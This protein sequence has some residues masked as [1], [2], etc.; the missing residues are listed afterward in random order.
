MNVRGLGRAVAVALALMLTPIA[1]MAQGFAG[2][3]GNADGFAHPSPNHVLTFP[4]D[5]AAHPGFR[6]EWWYVTANLTGQDGQQYGVQWT[7]FRTALRPDDTG[8][9]G[10][11]SPQVWLGHAGLSTPDAHFSAQRLARGG[12]GL[13]G[14]RTVPFGAWVDEWH[15]SAPESGPGGIAALLLSAGGEDFSFELD[16]SA[17]GP[18]VAHGQN[19]YS[20]KSASGQASTYYSQPFY[21]A[22]GTLVF[23]AQ[24]VQVS[25]QAW[26]DREWS[27]QPLADDQDGWDW[28]S[29]HLDGGQKLMGFRLR[30]KDGGHF[31]SGTWISA[32][33]RATALG[34]DELSLNPL[35]PAAKTD[36][37]APVEWRLVVP[38]HGV[39]V[40]VSAMNPN[41]WMDVT[42]PYWEGPVHV[43]GSHTGR[44]FL[45]MTGYR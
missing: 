16:L 20:V 1:A 38:A 36:H 11:S 41:S 26:L 31:H 5:H 40:T 12:L 25:G 19:G 6:I 42:P 45:E 15:I 32:D 23:G 4:A 24:R 8:Q 44:G 14:V 2:L 43:S 13:A 21:K 30:H 29:L 22:R 27:S 39:D 18:L 37:T 17:D 9:T 10:W 7:L 28:V 35:G 3:G 34:P 33:G